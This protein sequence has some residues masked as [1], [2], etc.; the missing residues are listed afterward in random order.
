MKKFSLIKRLGFFTFNNRLNNVG[1]IKIREFPTHQ[2]QFFEQMA[3]KELEKL[4]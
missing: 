4:Y 2:P 3:S 1:K